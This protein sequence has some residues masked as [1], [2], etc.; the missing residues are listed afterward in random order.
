MRDQLWEW[1]KYSSRSGMRKNQM[2][3]TEEREVDAEV[4]EPEE[5][6]RARR[7]LNKSCRLSI[8]TGPLSSLFRTFEESGT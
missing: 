3:H 6:K 5:L 2:W 4:D 7:P 8:V 1:Q